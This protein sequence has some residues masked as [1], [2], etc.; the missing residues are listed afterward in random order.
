MKEGLSAYSDFDSRLCQVLVL[1]ISARASAPVMVSPTER[2]QGEHRQWGYAVGE[3]LVHLCVGKTVELELL[4]LRNNKR[5]L[6]EPM[7]REEQKTDL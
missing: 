6:A 4:F 3:C 7:K 2:I 5:K 1:T